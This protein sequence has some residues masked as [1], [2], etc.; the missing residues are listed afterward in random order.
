MRMSPTSLAAGESNS[1]FPTV[2]K[3][4]QQQHPPPSFPSFSREQSEKQQGK[5]HPQVSH[6][7][8]YGMLSNT[9]A[10]SEVAQST[11]V[12]SSNVSNTPLNLTSQ[13]SILSIPAVQTNSSTILQTSNLSQSLAQMDAH[14]ISATCLDSG[15]IGGESSTGLP[16]AIAASLQYTSSQG[17]RI[18][19]VQSGITDATIHSNTYSQSDAVLHDSVSQKKTTTKKSTTTRKKG[20]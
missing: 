2:E 17:I 10:A 11:I 3:S 19:S 9:A 1:A 20:L 7:P 18:S 13:Q 14:M 15:N 8:D 4:Q 6:I 5:S 12:N 16:Q